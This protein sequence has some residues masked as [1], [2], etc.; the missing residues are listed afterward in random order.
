MVLSLPGTRLGWYSVGLAATF[1]VLFIVNAAVLLPAPGVVAWREALVGIALLLCA[2]GGE[3]AAL[4]ALVR[5]HER[6]ALVWLA[7]LPGLFVLFLLIGE[8]L[9]PLFD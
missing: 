9:V 5:R 4:I 7:M 6:S 1:V 3:V 8:F 2:L